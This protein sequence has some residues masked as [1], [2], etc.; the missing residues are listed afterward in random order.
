MTTN[1][2]K[3]PQH[4]KIKV[5]TIVIWILSLALIVVGAFLINQLHTNQHLRNELTT[6]TAN[7]KSQ[8]QTIH[9]LNNTKGVRN[10]VSVKT[11][12]DQGLNG[13]IH[14]LYDWD[15][16]NYAQRYHKA[17]KYMD[18]KVLVGIASNGSLPS[19][20]AL[21]EAQK[22]YA[23][24]H[25]QMNVDEIENGIQNIQ[26]NNVTGFVWVTMTYQAYGKKVQNTQQ[27]KYS[28]NVASK[29]FNSFLVEPFSGGIQQ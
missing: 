3:H 14:A 25:A 17:E 27:I 29:K 9:S 10:F 22:S 16:S 19:H 28:Y 18:K 24:I 21:E 13:A 15:G 12:T 11:A 6:Q 20:A 26:G 2:Q 23:K 5:T 4:N 8:Q 7:I 1:H